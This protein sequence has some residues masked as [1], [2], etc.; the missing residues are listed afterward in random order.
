VEN[1]LR[2]HP[3]DEDAAEWFKKLRRAA[4]RGIGGPKHS[5]G[6]TALML[7]KIAKKLE[8]RRTAWSERR[9]DSYSVGFA[10]GLRSEEIVIMTLDD[11]QV[12][13]DHEEK[14]VDFNI[15]MSKTNPE[16][17]DVWRSSNCVCERNP[18]LQGVCCF[19]R[20]AKR[21]ENRG[22]AKGE[23]V[24][25]LGDDPTKVVPKNK[26]MEEIRKD[27]AKVGVQTQDADGTERFGTHGIRRGTAQAMARAGWAEVTIQK[28]LRWESAMVAL[29][30]AEAPLALSREV[31][32]T[33]FGSGDQA[34][35]ALGLPGAQAGAALGAV[36]TRA[37]A[38]RKK[39]VGPKEEDQEMKELLGLME[40]EEEDGEEVEGEE[41]P[42]EEGEEES[43]ALEEGAEDSSELEE[44]S[45]EEEVEVASEEEWQAGD[46]HKKEGRKRSRRGK[47]KGR[48]SM[49]K[50]GSGRALSALLG[51]LSV[52]E[53]KVGGG[54]P[55]VPRKEG[56][57]KGKPPPIV[58]V[59]M[60]LP[61][62]SGAVST[63]C[64][65]RDPLIT[66]QDPL[67]R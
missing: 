45:E 37:V 1:F 9:M 4:A 21:L 49:A 27:L 28:F 54:V 55:P 59:G 7:I 42:E 47:K 25:Y 44:E 11:D 17:R 22:A 50:Y 52:R 36:P 19:H 48:R 35:T 15:S 34:G 29:Y 46:L 23:R 31:A 61:P 16:Q 65:N 20:M 62:V 30:V 38:R 5:D 39:D 57:G 41:H 64:M 43:L 32:R 13:L 18:D 63:W 2:G 14:R 67:L 33:L 56:L 12:R 8:V 6:V 24:L 51:S 40:E 3:L 66:G 53:E 60:W 10:I 26:F 58:G